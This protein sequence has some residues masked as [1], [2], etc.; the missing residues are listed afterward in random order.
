MALAITV[1]FLAT[2]AQGR[3]RP[4]LIRNEYVFPALLFVALGASLARFAYIRTIRCPN[5]NV[6]FGMRNYGGWFY[7]TPWP[8]RQCWNC[9]ADMLEIERAKSRSR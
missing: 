2:D 5:C 8:K 3:I 7:H 9:G 1:L 4:E 6:R